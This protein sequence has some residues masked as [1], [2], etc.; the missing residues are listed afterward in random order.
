MP[1]SRNAAILLQRM[2]HLIRDMRLAHYALLPRLLP[3]ESSE[4][5]FYYNAFCAARH[6]H[7]SDHAITTHHYHIFVGSACHGGV[8]GCVA[9]RPLRA[10]YLPHPS[11]IFASRSLSSPSFRHWILEP[12]DLGFLVLLI[13][14]SSDLLLP[15]VDVTDRPGYDRIFPSPPFG[16]RHLPVHCRLVSCT[17]TL[18]VIYTDPAAP[19]S[20]ISQSSLEASTI[21]LP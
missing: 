9:S 19:F 8:L 15:C 3:R 12:L 7:T 21:C 16:P 11:A 10:P 6:S 2:S 18:L 1:L 5:S 20:H 4:P 17:C 14:S 13:F